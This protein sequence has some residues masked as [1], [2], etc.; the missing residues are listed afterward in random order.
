MD[1]KQ[2]FQHFL[3]SKCSVQLSDTVLVAVSGGA[4]SM[5]LLHLF[6]A[7]NMK[8]VAAH[9]NFHLRGDESDRDESLVTSWCSEN[10]VELHVNHFD[11]KKYSVEKGLSVEMAARELRYRW[12][13]ELADDHGCQWIATGHHKDDSIETFFLNLSRGTGIKGLSGIKPCAGRIIRPLLFMQHN[14]IVS[15]CD[16]NHIPWSTDSSNLEN[17]YL[18]NKIRN[19]IL[20]LF[21]QINPSFTSTMNENINRLAQLEAF[22]ED[23]VVRQRNEIVSEED[24]CLLI[25]IKLIKNHPHRSLL[26]FEWLSPLGFNGAQVED[27]ILSLEGISGRQFL[28]SSHRL[29]RDRDNLVILPLVDIGVSE[30]YIDSS[31]LIISEP[32]GL[33]WRIFEKTSD[34]RFSTSPDI[35]HLD[36]DL[37]DF[38]MIIRHWKK[39]DEFRPLGMTGFKKLSDFFID[40]KLSLFEKEKIWLLVSGE[41]IIWVINHRVDDRYKITAKTKNIMEIRLA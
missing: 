39:G 12:F 37:V 20:P 10:G 23:E 29:V 9:V 28:S 16:E 2:A 5:A 7:L 11:T 17:I 31:Q 41:D 38:P 19:D 36:A 40:M 24:G 35:V 30:Y 6:V 22:M 1:N 32:V 34:F 8:V 25:P 15:Y 14:E 26:L 4:D 21:H 18:R 33:S 3:V 13:D 27:V